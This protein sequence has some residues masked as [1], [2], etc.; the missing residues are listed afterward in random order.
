MLDMVTALD[1]VTYLAQTGLTDFSPQAPELG[2][3]DARIGGAVMWAAY[4]AC[5]IAAMYAG[6][7]MGWERWNSGSIESPKRLAGVFFGAIIVAS[8]VTIVNW[9]AS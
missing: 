8:A 4:F 9:A 3:K 7:K 2:G 5:A 6:G 1:Q